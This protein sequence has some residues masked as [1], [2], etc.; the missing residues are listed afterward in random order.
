M[1]TRF[2]MTIWR[3]STD[4]LSYV[5]DFAK[6]R[7]GSGLGYLY[8]LSTTLAFFGLLPF[9][10]GL[11]VVSPRLEGF[12]NEQLRIARDAYPDEL[13]LTLS[14][15]VLS[16][17]VDEPYAI[18][19]PPEWR[20]GDDGDEPLHAVTID[21]SANIEDFDS[22]A[23][24]VLLTARY[25]VTRD[26]NGVR[27]FDYSELDGDVV[28]SEEEISAVTTG[29]SG[30]APALPWIGWG[31]VLA[32]LLV[33]PWVAGGAAWLVHLAYLS[34]MTLVVW[35]IASIAGRRMRYGELFRLGL[36][37]ITSSLLLSFASTMTGIGLAGGPSLL[38]LGW[39]TYVV[40]QFPA[41]AAVP[42]PPPPAATAKKPAARKAPAPKKAPKKT[43]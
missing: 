7:T 9:A 26:D 3:A 29:L 42:P 34:W 10:I 8:W 35:A 22:S 32:L 27:T 11:A 41:R 15:G 31:L 37:G 43:A 4:A 28:V 24:Y 38:F 39:M 16:T 12:V 17:N 33:L 21:T 5:E 14:G 30:Y 1:L 13:V 40:L 36:F 20:V 25:A 2:A 19:L 6:R 23:S 18:D